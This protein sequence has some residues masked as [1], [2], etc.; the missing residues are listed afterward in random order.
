[1]F[2]WSAKRTLLTRRSFLMVSTGMTRVLSMEGNEIAQYGDAGFLALCGVELHAGDIVFLHRRG[3][4]FAVGT[5]RRDCRRVR[6]FHDIAVHKIKIVRSNTGK[7]R[8]PRRGGDVVPSDMRQAQAP[9][10]EFARSPRDKSQAFSVASLLA[11]FRQ[12]LHAK[13]NAQKRLFLFQHFF[14]Q[15]RNKPALPQLPHAVAKRA[16][17]GEDKVRRALKVLRARGKHA[18]RAE[19][20][21]RVLHRCDVPHPVIND[22]YHSARLLFSS[23][24]TYCCCR[25]V[26]L[27]KSGMEIAVE[28][29]RSAVGQEP[30]L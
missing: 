26:M 11:R 23:R 17:A 24:A 29:N 5:R 2:R 12:Q 4:G 27:G 20:S 13:T 8:R 30:F 21:E 9:R 14:L 3:K 7:Q 6:R 16:H 18:L 25:S 28:Y 1:M 10:T 19:Q 22:G 15:Q